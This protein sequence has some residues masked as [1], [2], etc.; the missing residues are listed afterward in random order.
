MQ[1]K[2]G[3]RSSASEQAAPRAGCDSPRKPV[4]EISGEIAEDAELH[5]DKDYLLRFTT[6]VSP[7]ATLSIEP[8]TKIM[9]DMETKG[10]L[11][12]QPGARIVA[13]GT[14]DRPIVFTSSAPEGQQRP[15]DWGGLDSAW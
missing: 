5:C 12:V 11:V 1:E 15:G 4:V 8:G 6:Y 10:V 2:L 9:G 14:K 3:D 7:G 13:Q